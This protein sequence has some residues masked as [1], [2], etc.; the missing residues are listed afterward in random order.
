MDNSAPPARYDSIEPAPPQPLDPPGPPN[1]RLW[2]GGCAVGLFVATAT[3]WLVLVSPGREVCAR[4]FGFDFLAFYTAG[5][6]VREGRT[7]D[8]YDLEQVA[9]FQRQVAGEAGL[10]L[11]EAVGPWWNPPFYARLFVPLA[12]LPFRAALAVWTA[13]NLAAT[14]AAVCVLW[15]MLGVRRR[16]WRTW[17]LVPL[18]VAISPPFALA[19][20]HGQ[21]TGTSLLILSLVVL[22]WQSRRAALAGAVLGLLAYKPQLAAVVTLVLVLDLGWRAAA[23][24]AATGAVLLAVTLFTLPGT[25][26]DYL[27]RLP[28]NLHAIQIES[29]YLWERHVTIKAF[30]RLLLQGRGAGEASAAVTWMTTVCTALLGAML[31]RAVWQSR[32]A[33]RTTDGDPSPDRARDR[34]ITATLTAAPLAMPFYF[35]YDLLLL[36]VP[37]V[38]LAAEQVHER[39]RVDARP[40]RRRRWLVTCWA[41]LFL[42]LMVN[43]Y[44][45]DLTRLNG[46]VVL[47]AATAG[48]H[49][50]RT[51]GRPAAAAGATG[52]RE[53]PAPLRHAA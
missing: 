45:A 4:K 28:E 30:W 22:A 23:G 6:F 19:V 33:T 14:A 3:L 21:S 1:R 53:M 26:G 9:A 47:L 51:T 10:D 8:L 46:A 31:L 35:D 18:L 16:D 2:L 32:P 39:R 42:W 20:T 13:L 38:L 44:V 36:A 12:A 40:A 27:H 25:L 5:S 50:A 43:P 17:G 7:Q 48:L 52:S 29:P 41:A 24:F 11:G 15:R 37:A 49:L 34:L